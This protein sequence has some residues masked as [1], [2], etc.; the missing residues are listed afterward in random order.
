M[1]GRLDFSPKKSRILR[2]FAVLGPKNV[3]LPSYSDIDPIH[4]SKYI[5]YTP[6][7]S[8]PSHSYFTICTFSHFPVLFPEMLSF[9]TGLLLGTLITGPVC[10]TTILERIIVVSKQHKIHFLIFLIFRRLL[11][12][13]I[14]LPPSPNHISSPPHINFLPYT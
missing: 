9:I 5:F 12:C 11:F 1:Y 8:D 7:C 3:T 4:Q 14:Y 6:L 2:F 10:S 13:E